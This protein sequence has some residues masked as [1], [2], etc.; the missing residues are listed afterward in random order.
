MINTKVSTDIAEKQYNHYNWPADDPAPIKRDYF[1][2]NWGI[3]SDIT[4]SVKNL[5]DAEKTQGHTLA[6]PKEYLGVQ[7]ESD[8]RLESDPICSSAGCTQY[9]HPAKDRGYKIDY[10]VPH[11]GAD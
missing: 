6:I 2:P 10:F 4:D 5:A 8:L 7:T 1:V 3:D 9:R 11:F